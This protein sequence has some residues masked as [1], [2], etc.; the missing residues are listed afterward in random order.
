MPG[1]STVLCGVERDGFLIG[2]NGGS[3][4]TPSCG[5]RMMRKVGPGIYLPPRK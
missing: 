4:D 2:T 3:D 5:V 1:K